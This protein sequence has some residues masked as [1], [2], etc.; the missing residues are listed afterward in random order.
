MPNKVFIKKKVFRNCNLGM[1]I[2]VFVNRDYLEIEIK[3]D[4]IDF[5]NK[6]ELKSKITEIKINR[7]L[8][9]LFK[10]NDINDYLKTRISF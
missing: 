5:R 7:V 10:N 4:I 1:P 3:E 8:L 9:N 2:K 6:T